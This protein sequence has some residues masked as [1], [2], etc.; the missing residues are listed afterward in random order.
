MASPCD[1]ADT[2]CVHVADTRGW[3][4][5]GDPPLGDCVRLDVGY[6]WYQNISITAPC[7]AVPGDRDTI[8]AVIAYCGEEVCDTGCLDL[9]GCEDPNVWNG[10]PY[11]S[12]DTLIIEVVPSP[13]RVLIL[14]DTLAL[15]AFGQ[16]ANHIPFSICNGDPCGSSET[17]DY[18]FGDEGWIP[19]ND[20]YPRTGSVTV[21]GGECAEVYAVLDASLSEVCDFDSITLIAWDRDTGASRD[22]GITLV[23]VIPVMPVPLFSPS[24]VPILAAAVLATGAFFLARTA[25][26]LKA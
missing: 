13:P 26:R 25:G 18:E 24:L 19:W 5:T 20:A 15:A 1:Q 10:T 2:F 12:A 23:H 11:Y 9:P 21:A 17:Y 16:S 22:T 3:T 7:S 8:I 4:L 6:L 14:C